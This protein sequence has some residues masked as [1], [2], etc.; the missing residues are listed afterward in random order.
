[1]AAGPKSAFAHQESIDQAAAQ[2]HR[3]G[4]HIDRSV[5]LEGSRLTSNFLIGDRWSTMRYVG[6]GNSAGGLFRELRQKLVPLRGLSSPRH[7]W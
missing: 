5:S 3:D 7:R 1:V 6:Q 2:E 4:L